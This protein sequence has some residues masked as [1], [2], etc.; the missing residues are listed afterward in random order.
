MG[1]IVVP[2]RSTRQPKQIV[3]NHGGEFPLSYDEVLSLP[4]IGRYTAGAILS[5]SDAQRLPVLEG[6]T[7]RVYSRWL[8][9]RQPP[10]EKEAN[11]LLWKFAES[12]LPRSSNESHSG[13]FNQAAMELGALVCTPKQPGCA[14]C[15]V[16]R[17][18]A[19]FAEGSQ[20][21]I[22]GKITKTKYEDRTEF[23]F[24]IA[25]NSSDENESANYLLRPLPEG[26]RWAGLW[27][28][29][30]PTEAHFES[31]ETAADWLSNELGVAVR[32]GTR[33]KTIKHAVT[34]YRITLHV[35]EAKIRTSR[36]SPKPPWQW[37]GLSEIN[38]LP[39]SVTGRKIAKMFGWGA[40][41]TL[42]FELTFKGAMRQPDRTRISHS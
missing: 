7:Q 19:A 28:F 38:E 13:I 14:T 18:C 3:E 34:K 37:L 30:R 35:H 5:I 40:P 6:N 23:A 20:G 1:T 29:P 41:K 9:L 22:P 26:G 21:E 39:M 2:D 32:P 36:R 42:A 17:Q 16:K 24:V 15:P 25:G 8:G 33:L 27:D 11:A 12:I 31:A 10:A 4:G